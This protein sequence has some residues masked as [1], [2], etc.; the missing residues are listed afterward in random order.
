MERRRL[1]SVTRLTW[2]RVSR[3][4]RNCNR[5]IL[6]TRTTTLSRSWAAITATLRDLL[7]QSCRQMCSRLATLWTHQ[8]AANI[9]LLLA[10]LL[11]LWSRRRLS[12]RRRQKRWLRPWRHRR[13]Q[14]RRQ[15]MTRSLKGK[16]RLPGRPM[17]RSRRRPRGFCLRRRR[18]R[19]KRKMLRKWRRRTPKQIKHALTVMRWWRQRKLKLKR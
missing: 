9:A 14:I 5:A 3:K 13:R 17:L 2:R 4:L 6:P 7:A 1:Q 19:R 18:R 8:A 10:L 12:K 16:W 11:S 15:Q